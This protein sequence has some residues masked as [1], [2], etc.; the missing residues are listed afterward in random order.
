MIE[1][2]KEYITC[3]G[4]ES[5][6]SQERANMKDKLT[7]CIIL[8]R[9]YRKTYAVVRSQPIVAGQQTFNFSENYVFG[10]FDAFCR[11]LMKIMAMFDLIDDYTGL[12]QRRMEGLLL[13]DGKSICYS[14]RMSAFGCFKSLKYFVYSLADCSRQHFIIS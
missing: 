2:C 9:V 7:H 6:W 12:F 8:N 11:R 4:Q 5:I 14:L 3:R 13:G 1:T 10:K